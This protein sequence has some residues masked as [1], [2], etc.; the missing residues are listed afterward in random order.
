MART[1]IESQLTA[2]PSSAV[3]FA[4]A[5]KDDDLAIRR[6]L[7][8]N[9]MRGAISVSFEREPGYFHG[10]QIAGADDQTILAFAQG[11]LVCMGRCSVRERYVNG[12]IRRVGYLSDLRLDHTASGRFDILRRG[13]RFFHELERADPAD[14]YFTSITADNA[15]SVRFL[16]R[17]LPGM[18]RYERLADF[19]TLLIPVP[20]KA[21]QLK[22]LNEKASSRLN[23][24]NIE[25]MTGSERHIDALVDFLNSQA[26]R[27]NLAIAWS[28]DKFSRCNDTAWSFPGL[29]CS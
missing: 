6:L 29:R 10:T 14:F 19:V 8:E 22:Q 18:P 15:R 16:E 9:P 3:R 28:E 17:G 1:I 13:Y 11:R 24:A 7:R 4:L 5:T 26:K 20:R 12:E 2:R 27:F 21:R 23:S 25:V